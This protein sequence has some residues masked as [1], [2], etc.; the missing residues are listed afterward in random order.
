[1]IYTR[2]GFYWYEFVF[3]GRRYRKTTDIKVGRGFLG[4]C[5]RKRKQKRLKR[6]SERSSRWRPQHTAAAAVTRLF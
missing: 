5:L 4:K 3:N 6:L 1:M 2:G